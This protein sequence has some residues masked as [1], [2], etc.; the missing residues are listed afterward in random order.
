MGSRRNVRQL[1]LLV[2]FLPEI[3][4]DIGN[5]AE[6]RLVHLTRAVMFQCGTPETSSLWLNLFGL[7]IL[8]ARL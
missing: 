7:L 1:F 6:R 8:F 4:A 3:V 5:A 2:M